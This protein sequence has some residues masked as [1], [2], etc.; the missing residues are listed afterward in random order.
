MNERI[1]RYGPQN[2]FGS[3]RFI[4]QVID[5]CGEYDYIL[6]EL[7]PLEWHAGAMERM[8]A[9]MDELKE[10]A[11]LYSAGLCHGR[12]MRRGQYEDWTSRDGFDFGSAILFRS[13]VL[14]QYHL[15]RF[16]YAGFYALCLSVVLDYDFFYLDEPLYSELPSG[17]SQFDY[18]RPSSSQAQVEME[19]VF[20]NYL[21]EIDAKLCPSDRTI[22]LTEGAFPVELSVV[23]PVF[24]RV[25][26]IEDAVRS[27]LAQQTDGVSF[28]VIVVDNH[29][30]DGTTAVIDN[31]PDP[32]LVHIIPEDTGLG[33][34]GCWNLAVNDPRCGRFAVQLDSDDLYSRPDALGM[35]YD[36]FRKR[37]VAMVVG[38]Y[39]LTDMQG[40]E[41]EPGLIAHREWTDGNGHN[42]LLRVNGI[43]APR[44][45]HVPTLRSVGGFPNVSY[46]EDYAV[47]LRLSREWPVGRIFESL[48]QC[49]RWEGNSDA[50][51]SPEQKLRH[52]QYKDML[53][54]IEI[55]A[56]I[57]INQKDNETIN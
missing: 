38:A 23:I 37:R 35:I 57:I 45:F 30:D 15:P 18:C 33:I 51:L 11:V 6:F 34:G 52:D 19:S 21:T 55:N 25:R 47:A 26:T 42:N 49:R 39:T 17:G 43:G 13:E 36:L 41:I 27:A 12:L 9:V 44:A 7:R 3:S 5:E 16:K 46:G 8:L 32:R 4:N 28:N 40:N 24:N 56:R 20:T 14:A 54:R 29:S 10:S 1:K 2:D 31:I 22:D 50:G 48:Y 53:R